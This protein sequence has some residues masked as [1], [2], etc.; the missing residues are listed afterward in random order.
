MDRSVNLAL[1]NGGTALTFAGASPMVTFNGNGYLQ[2]D[3]TV[4]T[5][6]QRSI[7]RL[8]TL[9][10]D[11]MFVMWCDITHPTTFAAGQA[12][13]FYWGKNA[14]QGWGI[15]YTGTTG[16]LMFDHVS[17]SGNRQQFTFDPNFQLA[18][19][20]VNTRTALCL[21]ISR[22]NVDCGG[23][24]KG[25]GL[26]EIEVSKRGITN[27]GPF[28]QRNFTRVTPERVPNIGVAPCKFD[29]VVG[30]TIGARPT[31]GLATN[32]D[33]MPAGYG[34]NSIG[35]ARRKRQCAFPLVVTRQ[36]T[37]LIALGQAQ[38]TMPAACAN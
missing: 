6:I 29:S 18:I 12:S 26:F 17:Q 3:Q 33:N 8:D 23:I 5:L 35:F 24:G 32:A 38:N 21:T 16:R 15:S 20:G 2:A 14:T 36:L 7:F 1:T 37:R 22:A 4:M 31:T 27:Q 34:L 19:D 11:E 10:A 9:A 30:L 25:N 28:T 13:L